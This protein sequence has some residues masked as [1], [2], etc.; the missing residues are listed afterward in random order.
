MQLPRLPK[1]PGTSLP[2]LPHQVVQVQEHACRRY[3][4]AAM[5]EVLF[6]QHLLSLPLFFSA[7]DP[8]TRAVRGWLASDPQ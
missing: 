6:Y 8:L 4:K 1:Q 7:W 5:G 2:V 3:G